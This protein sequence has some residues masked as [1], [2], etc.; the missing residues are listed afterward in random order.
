MSW[1]IRAATS[2]YR[3]LAKVAGVHHDSHSFR[4]L[5]DERDHLV[6]GQD[7]PLGRRFVSG[8]RDAAGFRLISSSSFAAVFRIALSSR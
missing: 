2:P 6:D 1:R 7:G 5:F 4:C 3:R 8:A